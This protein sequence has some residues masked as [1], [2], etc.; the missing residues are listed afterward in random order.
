MNIHDLRD[1]RLLQAQPKRVAEETGNRRWMC[2]VE[3]IF[4]LKSTDENNLGSKLF[5]DGVV[6]LILGRN[7]GVY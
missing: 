3:L 5:L 1:L 4:E 2:S 6:F 7:H